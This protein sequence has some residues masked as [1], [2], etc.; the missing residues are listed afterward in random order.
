[1]TKADIVDAIAQRT[2]MS[3]TE[4]QAVVKSF[5]DAIMDAMVQNKRIEIRGFG[6]FKTVKRASRTGRNPRTGDVVDIPARYLPVFKPSRELRVRVEKRLASR[7][8]A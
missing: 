8:A 6:T 4:T 7:V 1:M 5:I 3:K 2:G